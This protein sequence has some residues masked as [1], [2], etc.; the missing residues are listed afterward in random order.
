MKEALHMGGSELTYMGNV[1]TAGYV[2]GQLPVVILSMKIRPSILVSTLEILWAVFTFA[3]ASV[4][5]VPLLYALRFLVGL[6]EGAFF[7][8][9][10]YLISSWCKSN[11]CQCPVTA[12]KQ[13][14]QRS[15]TANESPFT[16][17]PP[18]SYVN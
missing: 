10:I 3:C 8:V 1:F 4:K 14:K 11:L 12:D 9:I 18:A 13:Q 2:V 6:C 5:A 17:L 16:M 15:S 7:P